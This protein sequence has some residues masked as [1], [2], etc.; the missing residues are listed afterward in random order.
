MDAECVCRVCR[1]CAHAGVSSRMCVSGS[2]WQVSVRCVSVRCV[3]VRCVSVGCVSGVC[4][5][6]VVGEW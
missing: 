1:R 6:C 3:S 5:R 4:V 2:E